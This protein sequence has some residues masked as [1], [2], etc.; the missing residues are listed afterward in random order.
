[1]QAHL[2]RNPNRLG[3]EGGQSTGSLW[4]QDPPSTEDFLL[5]LAWSLA[6]MGAHRQAEHTLLHIL[7]QG[8]NLPL[9]WLWNFNGE[10]AA[11]QR[12]RT[13][14][15]AV[16][17]SPICTLVLPST[18]PLHPQMS[19]QVVL[20][21]AWVLNSQNLSCL[22]FDGDLGHGRSGATQTLESPKLGEA[23]WSSPYCPLT[24]FWP[25]SGYGQPGQLTPLPLPS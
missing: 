7:R 21:P 1:M 24:P 11:I 8:A 13:L 18:S 3:Q 12:P 4:S 19:L 23:S 6:H 2:R 16:L 20:H 15:I 17:Q 9:L 5:P 22:M 14:S 10:E 25:L